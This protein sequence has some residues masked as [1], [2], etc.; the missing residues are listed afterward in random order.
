[1]ALKAKFFAF[2]EYHL[3]FIRRTS[4]TSK[5]ALKSARKGKKMEETERTRLLRQLRETQLR[6]NELNFLANAERGGNEAAETAAD[7]LCQRAEE[8]KRR[9]ALL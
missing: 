4:T 8:I 7:E 3:V 1:M 2:A 6:I 9:L 5:P